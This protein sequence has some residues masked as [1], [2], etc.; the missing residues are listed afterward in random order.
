MTA[1][2]GGILALVAAC[3][4]WGLSPIL[5]RI[6]DHVPA[7]DV[8][9]HRVLW[10]VVFFLPLVGMQH[11]GTELRIAVSSPRRVLVLLA[12][13]LMI[14]V[15]W[16]IFVFAAQL[17]HLVES[18]LGYYIYPLIAVL[19]GVVLFGERPAR[20]Q[21]LAV[22]VATLGVLVLTI[23]L[24]AAPWISLLLAMTFATYGA[25][26]RGI[27]AHPLVSV[28]A[29][30][31]LMLPVALLWILWHDG[32]GIFIDWP[33]T[34]L[35]ISTG[36][37]TALPLVLFSFAAKKLTSATLGIL[38]YVNPT[39][40]FLCGTVL[41]SEP[42]TRW[43]AIAFPLIWSAVALYSVALVRASRRSPRRDRAASASGTA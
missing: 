17:G 4:I 29:E 39:L 38:F 16:T 15:N 20:T 21:I 8:M 5:Y 33:T 10:S 3:T 14:G 9:A 43:H 2:T 40:Q 27:A 25:L 26:K 22:G 19:F 41:F 1:R 12:A 18:S 6:L 34:I 31:L 32:A 13:A 7:G 23:G 30:T 24:G 36:P 11:R 35:L 42:F 28:T 37:L